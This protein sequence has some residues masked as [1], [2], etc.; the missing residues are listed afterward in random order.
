MLDFSELTYH[1]D[2][3]IMQVLQGSGSLFMDRFMLILTGAV[4]WIPLYISLLYLVIRN[5]ETM[6]QIALIV[7]F[8]VL[9]VALS[10]YFVDVLVKPVFMRYRPC[11]DPV[12]RYTIDVVNGYRGG[13][14]GFFSAH[15]SNTMSIALF[16]CLTIRSRLLSVGLILWSVVNCYTRIYLGVHYPSDVIVGIVWGCVAAIS[17]YSIYVY[18]EKRLGI[19]HS[20]ISNQYTSKGYAYHDI[21]IVLTVLVA[22][23]FYALFRSIFCF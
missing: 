13:I 10:D 11:H 4:T 16:F 20:Y 23:L 14:Y 6:R 17:V 19:K 7:F 22:T 5:N 12:L 15:A 18:V 1:F 2:L 21:Y 3:P 8:A 9:T